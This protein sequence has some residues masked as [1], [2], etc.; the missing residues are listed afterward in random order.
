MK[1][2]AG[3]GQMHM[4]SPT[5]GKVAALVGGGMC[6]ARRLIQQGGAQHTLN[7]QVMSHA[8]VH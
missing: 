7:I 1:L 5:A 4:S 2:H 8:M 6:Q 3:I